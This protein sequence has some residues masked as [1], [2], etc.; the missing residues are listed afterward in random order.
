MRRRFRI[1]NVLIGL[2]V[3]ATC[4]ARCEQPNVS[5]PPA[6]PGVSQFALYFHFF[7]SVD[8]LRNKSE[9]LVRQGHAGTQLRAHYKN[10]AS[11]NQGQADQV[12]TV[13]LD[14]LRDLARQDEQARRV[15]TAW[16]ARY[17][18]GRL[19]EGEK[20]P[21]PPAELVQLQKGREEIVLRARSR[22][23]QAFGDQ[24]FARLEQFLQADVAPR[25]E[26]LPLGKLAQP[27]R[28]GPASG[29]VPVGAGAGKTP[30]Q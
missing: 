8:F 7:Q 19:L 30:R 6:Q 24:E 22:L 23:E 18:R 1:L 9:E 27:D 4:A 28:F 21:Q 10:R 16:R 29:P 15:I 20:P 12:E 2:G 25:I 13:A 11:L 3:V 26:P 5:P 17:P 14:C